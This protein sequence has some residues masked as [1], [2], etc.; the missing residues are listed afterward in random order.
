[1]ES[2]N[3]MD[4]K[5][6]LQSQFVPITPKDSLSS[7]DSEPPI[8]FP[9]KL[10]PK[11]R[12][13]ATRKSIPT[14]T[15]V[16]EALKTIAKPKETAAERASRQRKTLSLRGIQ[17]FMALKYFIT[18]PDMKSRMPHVKK[19]LKDLLDNGQLKSVKS[20]AGLTGSFWVPARSQL[21]KDLQNVK[22][23]PKARKSL[24]SKQKR[25][26]HKARRGGVKKAL[27]R[28]K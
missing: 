28:H 21:Q 2:E 8:P 13:L 23:K 4:D 24:K 11:T 17:Q 6:P 7:V 20:G 12:T 26:G 25:K 18:N 16:R 22:N 27:S 9:K 14:K 3:N 5:A 10:L 19:Y 1:M 15:M